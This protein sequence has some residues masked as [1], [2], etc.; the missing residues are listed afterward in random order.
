GL[1]TPAGEEGDLARAP[2]SRGL[3][4]R[5][6]RDEGDHLFLY[7]FGSGKE[8]QLTT[9][10][11]RDNVPRFSPDGKWVAFERDSKE[12]RLID[13]ASK[14][15]RTLATGV[16]DTPPFVEMRD[17]VWSPDSKYIAYLSAGAKTFQNVNVVPV[18]GGSARPITF[19]ANTNAGSLA[20]SP[21]GTFLTLATAQRTEPGD[22]IRVDLV[23][24]TPKYR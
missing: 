23:P 16:F 14:E 5:R 2:D 7:D 24:R 10:P 20:W 15:E 9:G 18:A 6:Q 17:F 12:L 13:P 1:T 22:V 11:L 3:P 19:L 21:D 4:Y 8:T